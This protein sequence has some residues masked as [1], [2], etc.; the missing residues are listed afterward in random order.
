[1]SGTKILAFPEST[2]SDLPENLPS[3]LTIETFSRPF[4]V[5]RILLP[6]KQGEVVA[7]CVDLPA[8]L[9]KQKERRSQA[10]AFHGENH[11]RIAWQIPTCEKPAKKTLRVGE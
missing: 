9:G 1:M 3:I 11:F 2:L 4:R 10:S 6:R 5:N 8:S 7:K